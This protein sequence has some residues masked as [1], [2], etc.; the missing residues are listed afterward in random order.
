MLQK[1]FV[2]LLLA[3]IGVFAACDYSGMQDFETKDT[4]VAAI[5]ENPVLNRADISVP[6]KVTKLTGKIFL[7]YYPD[8]AGK[9]KYFVL[10]VAGDTKQ[11]EIIIFN[12]ERVSLGFDKYVGLDVT[13][14]GQFGSGAIYPLKRLFE[15]F[16]VQKIELPVKI[17]KDTGVIKFI[18]LEGGFWGIVGKKANYDPVNLP[19]EF[20]KEG[21]LV[22]FS[23]VP[24]D[25]ASIHQWGILIKLI[26]IKQINV[27]PKPIYV[28]LNQK[29]RLKNS[30]TAIV[31]NKKIVFTFKE[32]L[33]D[34]RCPK[35]VTCVWQ[36]EGVIAVHVKIR[37]KDY[38]MFK[39][40]TIDKPS[41][42]KAGKF[43]F[44]FLNLAP[45]PVY[46]QKIDPADYVGTFVIRKIKKK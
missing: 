33:S 14:I 7:R 20:K 3:L 6:D 4:S 30:Q 19:D 44:E 13:L 36:G 45:Y 8:G 40:S 41:I 23:A 12:K 1:Y 38:G 31:K 17:I 5:A 28:K 22:E 11:K 37:N 32:V 16:I 43:T 25:G 42:I 10:Q 21:I 18:K 15:G 9:Y 34:S 46:G 39:M 2:F 24:Y 27:D 29:F 35:G 26:E